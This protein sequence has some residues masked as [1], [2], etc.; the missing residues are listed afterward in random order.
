MARTGGAY[1]AKTGAAPD[2][3]EASAT[4][5]PSLVEKSAKPSA[6]ART[7]R[8]ADGAGGVAGSERGG[9]TGAAGAGAALPGAG[10]GDDAARSGSADEGAAKAAT[11]SATLGASGKTAKAGGESKPESM[12]LPDAAPDTPVKATNANKTPQRTNLK[13]PETVFASVYANITIR[14]SHA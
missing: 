7:E 5:A 2:E 3:N 13:P 8:S 9:T 4:D 10:A 11:S 1:E 14:Q 12:A 6:S